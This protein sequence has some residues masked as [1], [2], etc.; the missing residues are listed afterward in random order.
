MLVEE[1][2]GKRNREKQG[3]IEVQILAKLNT[4]HLFPLFS[5]VDKLQY[6]SLSRDMLG[7]N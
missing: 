1:K 4:A 6:F 2:Q 5:V 3:Q 7:C